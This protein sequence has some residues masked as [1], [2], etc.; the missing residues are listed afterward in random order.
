MPGSLLYF[1]VQDD[2]ADRIQTIRDQQ[3]DYPSAHVLQIL[4]NLDQMTGTFEAKPV[5]VE[6]LE[7]TDEEI[8]DCD[9]ELDAEI[10][11]LNKAQEQKI[12]ES[13]EFSDQEMLEINGMPKI[14]FL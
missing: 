1:S 6:Q 12:T 10:S 11:K 9:A 8:D 3:V 4:A 2:I 5:A 7:E 13:D 14:I